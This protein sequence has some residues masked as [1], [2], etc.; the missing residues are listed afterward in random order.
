MTIEEQL[1]IMRGQLSNFDTL[2]Q[3]LSWLS[4][5]FD[6]DPDFCLEAR[7]IIRHELAQAE[8]HREFQ[9]HSKYTGE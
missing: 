9:A 4:M 5:G 7:N 8:A 3:K 1:K 6:P 2:L